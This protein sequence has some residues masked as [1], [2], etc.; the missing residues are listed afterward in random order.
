MIKLKALLG[1]IIAI[2]TLFVVL[3]TFIGNDYFAKKFVTVTSLK[4]S[5]IFTGGEVSK[6]LPLEG[7]QVK[8]HEPVFQGLFS[9]RSDGFVQIDYEGKNIPPIISQNIDYNNDGKDDFYIKYDVKNN[10]SEFK[11]LSKNV[12]ALE[13]I[14]KVNDSYAVRVTLKK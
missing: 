7:Y 6:T 11:S 8:I 13:G 1:Y 12:V 10:K 9:D 2:L 4:V 5:P 3:A 14:Y